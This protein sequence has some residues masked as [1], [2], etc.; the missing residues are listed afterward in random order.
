VRIDPKEETY[1][2]IRGI[3]T[4]LRFDNQFPGSWRVVFDGFTADAS[5]NGVSF[6]TSGSAR[7]THDS[8]NF[9]FLGLSGASG[10]LGGFDNGQ[11]LRLDD[12]EAVTLGYRYGFGLG[13]D[14]DRLTMGLTGS[15]FGARLGPRVLDQNGDGS[16]DSVTPP[17]LLGRVTA[18]LGYSD[19]LS[20]LYPWKGTSIGSSLSYSV[21]APQSI[22]SLSLNGTPLEVVDSCGGGLCHALTWI[23][24][25]SRLFSLD[26]GRVFG[27]RLNAAFLFG[28]PLGQ[29]LIDLGGNSGLKGYPL[30]VVEGRGRVYGSLEYRHPLWTGRD[31]NIAEVNRV[32]SVTGVVWADGA[33]ISGGSSIVGDPVRSLFGAQSF[34]AD[35]GVGLRLI[36][37]HLGIDPAMLSLDLALPLVDSQLTGGRLPPAQFF[38]GFDHNF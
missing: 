25:A 2:R 36:G 11:A 6:A 10:L 7:R 30:N 4:D 1:E 24:N 31:I 35:V 13:L 8:R 18:S 12:F 29:A 14:A 28:T 23:T 37:D 19:R 38:V 17:A 20:F 26:G 27:A 5:S 22:G 34:F 21:G 32:R 3:P 15:A 9:Y 33:T 16:A